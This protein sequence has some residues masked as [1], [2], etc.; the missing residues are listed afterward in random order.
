M[1][2]LSTALLLAFATLSHAQ[3]IL[4]DK[5]IGGTQAENMGKIREAADGGIIVGGYSW[6][7]VG[8]DKSEP[9][10]GQDDYWIVKLS[11]TGSIL[12]ENAIGGSGTDQLY[13]LV[14]T[15]DNGVVVAGQSNSPVSGDKTEASANTD[16]WVL[17][18]DQNGSILWQNTYGGSSSESLADI[19]STADGGFITIGFSASNISGDKTENSRGGL[20]Y[21]VVKLDGAG[22]V[23]WDKTLGGS[24]ND[25][26][27]SVIQTNDGGYLCFGYSESGASGDKTE[28]LI[29]LYDYWVVKLDASGN[30]IW[31]NT[32]GGTVDDV[33]TSVIQTS[34]GGYL[35]LGNSES[36]ISGDKTED[37]AGAFDYWMVKLD[38]LG[39]I[40]F[41]NVI[42]GQ[43]DEA[44]GRD[45]VQTADGGFLFNGASRSPASGDKSEQGV[46][47]DYWLVKTDSAGIVLWQNTIIGDL[48]D[49]GISVILSSDGNMI[50][51]GNSFSEIGFDKSEISRGAF[52]YWVLKLNGN[53]N[54]INGK[55]FADINGNNVQDAGEIS[56]PGITVTEPTSGIPGISSSSGWYSV[57][58]ENPGPYSVSP[59]YSL[60]YYNV[61]PSVHTATFTAM[62][63]IDSLND[64]AFQP[65]GTFDDLCI[66]LSPLTVFRSGQ[67]ASYRIDYTNKG[68]T[69]LT[70]TVILYPDANLTF[71]SSVPLAGSVSPDSVVFNLPTMNPFESGSATVT[72]LTAP[73][74]IFGTTITSSVKI[75]PVAGDADPSCNYDT[76]TTTIIGSF[77]PNDIQVD[78]DTLY[79]FETLSPPK[80]EY[81]IRFQ[82]TGNDTAFYVRINNTVSPLID[83]STLELVATSHECVVS[84]MPYDSTLRFTF[85]NILL[86]DS[87]VNEQA[88]HGFVRYRMRPFSNIPLGSLINSRAFIYFDY[89]APVA[90]NTAT[91]EVVLPTALASAPD[92][93]NISVYPNPSRDII[94]IQSGT[95]NE[96]SAI[97]I[98]DARGRA[99]T[100][101]NPDCSSSTGRCSVSV[102]TLPAGL[103]LVT[104]DGVSAGKFIRQ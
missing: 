57:L 59:T 62:N 13:S 33:A 18:L 65:A 61:N 11:A 4:W 53:F 101:L 41:Q 85:N 5:T 66:T 32:I 98:F 64:F 46:N 48:N 82:N 84:W 83:L 8:G 49:N 17:K 72:F 54:Q 24:S 67:Q 39:N 95:I 89:N 1:R 68:T 7:G 80:L 103:Y 71:V 40:L 94:Y 81:L 73:G 38:S 34:D 29:G 30:I 50:L 93:K 96:S 36:G 102:A 87:N 97:R 60:P 47:Y 12:W 26:P 78:R 28:P 10:N 51:G 20:D 27:A 9:L 79:T 75:L 99:L 91:T 2:L 70:P 76:L 86:P 37:P 21:W 19:K 45:L 15:P 56:L 16:V 14:T 88:S 77:D 90:T 63:Q 25:F 3:S 42:G 22:Q 6:S 43:N 92:I 55:L 100:G 74:L 58:L 44:A 69:T 31:Q 52:D 104:V 23:Q 35:C